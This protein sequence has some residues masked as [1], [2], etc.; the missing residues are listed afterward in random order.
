MR[1]KL[2]GVNEFR[3]NLASY[4]QHG[5]KQ[6]LRYFFLNRNKP[7]LEVKPLSKKEAILEK[8]A[9]DVAAARDDVRQ[10]KLYTLDQVRRKLGI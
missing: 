1:T 4:Y 9:A 5:L 7:I 6:K 10:G 8:L 3:Q 2:I